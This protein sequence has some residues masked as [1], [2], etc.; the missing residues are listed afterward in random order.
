[1]YIEN[2]KQH[3]KNNA[4]EELL[5]EKNW[6][7]PE[8]LPP[9]HSIELLEQHSKDSHLSWSAPEF[10]MVEQNKKRLSY[11][12]LV[13]L[14]IIVYA[15]FTNNPI[16]AIVFVLI[17]IVAYMYLNKE[18]RILNFQIVPEGILAGKEIYEFENIRSFWIFYNPEYKKVISLHIKSYLTPFVHIPINKED[19]VE[20]RRILLEYIPEIKQEHNA[21]EILERFLGI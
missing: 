2:H 21:V 20:I 15:T 7:E 17:G 4:E 6:E 19:P 5:L 18:P 11:A 9:P 13:L 10:D 8:M 16:M 3:P 1:M 12:A 14:A